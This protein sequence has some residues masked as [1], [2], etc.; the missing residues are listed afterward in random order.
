M[1]T[2]FWECI[3]GASGEGKYIEVW[4]KGIIIEKNIYNKWETHYTKNKVYQLPKSPG[5]LMPICW[6]GQQYRN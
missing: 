1:S 2:Y 3:L 6:E 5:K 4:G